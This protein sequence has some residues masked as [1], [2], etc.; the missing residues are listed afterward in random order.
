MTARL[1]ASDY[2]LKN[3]L[4]RLLTRGL[5]RP[6]DAATVQRV[7]VFR[8]GA[9]GDGVCAL[10]ALAALRANFPAAKIDLLT[11]TGGD[12][13]RVSLGQLVAPGVVDE[14]LDFQPGAIWSLAR[15]LRRR[16]YDLFIELSQAHGRFLDQLRHLFWARWV[17]FPSAFGWEITATR[18]F[19]Q[20][21]ERH[22]VFSDERTR[23]LTMLGRHGLVV[24]TIP[25]FPLAISSADE[26]FVENLLARHHLTDANRNV[27]L[28]V[29]A[30][31]AQNRWPLAYF[32]RVAAWL[33]EN[34]FRVLL[35]GGPDDARLA[36]QLPAH[37][38]LHCFAGQCT[39]LQSAVFLRHCRLCVANDT[40]AMHL[41][42]AVGTPVVALFSAR[43]YAGLWFPPLVGNPVL[44]TENAP[45][46]PCLSERCPN[47][48]CLQAIRPGLV[49]DR[50][51]NVLNCP[52]EQSF[53]LHESW[54]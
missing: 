31:R 19:R 39:P 18:F 40:G 28:V 30:Q 38:N 53:S 10:P 29:G 11:R 34:D 20:H 52:T 22:R 27:A 9:L 32:A 47:N 54:C 1:I 49:I 50:L 2:A 13:G 15:H 5:F 16:R 21:Q 48:R 3:G 23:L 26:V 51:A 37:P 46:S 45:C 25:A 6:L 8:V 43:D 33:L 7:L 4:L 12:A 42:Y 14:V 24:P 17:G 36:G 44:R 35:V 41:A